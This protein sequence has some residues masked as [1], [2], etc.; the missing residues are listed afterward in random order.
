M[1]EGESAR[2]GAIRLGAVEFSEEE[3]TV[4]DGRRILRRIRRSDG[5]SV[6][7]RHGFVSAHPLMQLVLGV[8]TV[9]GGLYPARYLLDRLRDGGSPGFVFLMLAGLVPLG[10]W[11]LFDALQRGHYL[12]LRT[13]STPLRVPLG[14]GLGRDELRNHLGRA[15]TELGWDVSVR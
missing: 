13:R 1:V 8:A 4:L 14:R 7:L 11:L 10:A 3:I 6:E 2:R 9:L 5:V 12:L 15:G